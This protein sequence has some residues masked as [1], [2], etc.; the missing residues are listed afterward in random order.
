MYKV[1]TSCDPVGM[2]KMI[3]KSIAV[4]GLLY[5]SPAMNYTLKEIE[6][7]Q[8]VENSVYRNLLEVA[9]FTPNATLKGE[10]GALKMLTRIIEERLIF[11]KGIQENN[12][13]FMKKILKNIEK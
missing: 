9:N 4:Q 7:L 3:W 1:K 2:G 10:I 8:I 11:L 12:N 13:E 5:A 6:G